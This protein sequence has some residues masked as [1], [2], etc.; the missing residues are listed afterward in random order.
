MPLPRAQSTPPKAN[1]FRCLVFGELCGR[2]FAALDV[3]RVDLRKM[4]PLLGQVIRR[5]N[6]GDRADRHA[7]ATVYALDGI[8]VE[9]RD[10]IERGTAVVHRS[11]SSWDGCN[12]RA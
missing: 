7:G 8:D 10:L 1:L 11:C 2:E 5:K 4:L 6:R 12:R 3:A 9:L